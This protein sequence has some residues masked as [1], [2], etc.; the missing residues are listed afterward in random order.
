MGKINV[1][2]KILVEKPKK[3]DKRC[4]SEEFLHEVPTKGSS[5]NVIRSPGVLARREL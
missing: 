1:N 5:R 2:D 4:G 3:N